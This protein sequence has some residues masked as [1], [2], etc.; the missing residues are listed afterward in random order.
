[1]AFGAYTG[2][3]NDSSAN[4]TVNCSNGGTY[5]VALG[6]GSNSNGTTRRMAGPSGQ[7]LTYAIYS[8]AGRTTTWGNGTTFGAQVSGTGTGSNQTLTAY[9]RVP[10]GQSPTPGS[11]TDTV[12]V[13]ITY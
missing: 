11:Y 7:F 3:N 8:N 9:G 1:M 12:V 10:S 5:T 2:V 13:T 4:V 6:A